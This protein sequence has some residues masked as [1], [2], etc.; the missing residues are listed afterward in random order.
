MCI[1]R[2]FIVLQDDSPAAG[3]TEPFENSRETLK[4]RREAA[5]LSDPSTWMKS[6]ISFETRL[7]NESIAVRLAADRISSA[8]IVA[9]QDVLFQFDRDTNGRDRNH[10]VAGSRV[11]QFPD[12]PA[13]PKTERHGQPSGRRRR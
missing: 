1:C 3:Q 9:M 12:H 11:P 13:G 4:I 8:E 2:R 5:L 6:W 7:I 10:D